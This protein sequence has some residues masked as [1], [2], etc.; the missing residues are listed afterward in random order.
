MIPGSVRTV[1]PESPCHSGRAAHRVAFAMP[2]IRNLLPGQPTPLGPTV[3]AEGINFA[4][5]SAGAT[6]VELLLY[7]NVTDQRPS[8][9]IPLT[10]EA[11]RTGDVWHIFVEGCR[12]TRR[13][14]TIASTVPTGRT[15]DGSRYNAA[16]VL[17]DP[18]TPAVTGDFYWRTADALGYDNTKPDDPD[19]HLRIGAVSNVDGASRCVAYRSDF[20]W[21]GDR[22]PDI[23]IEE[24]IIY[25]VNVRGFTRHHSSES[26]LGGTYR[27]FIEKIP[28]LKDLGV[29]AV[30][31]LPVFEF[32]QFDIPFR[33]PLTG[34]KLTN[35]WG[36][37]TVAFFAPESHYS[38]FGKVGE[39]VDEFKMLVRELH[40]EGIEVILDVVFNH[41][42]E[43]NHY[44]P[45]M[46]FKGLDNNIWYM[47]APKPEFY[48]D[49]TGCGNTMNC[50]HPVVRRFIL[51]CLKYWVTEM[52]VD[53]FRFDLAA[54]FAI[55]V[56]QQEKGKTP[57]IAEIESDPVLARTK[58]IAEPWSITQYRLG[59]FSDRRWAEWN[60]KF[61]D[62]LRRWIKGDGG[63]VND[64]AAR[65]TGSFDLFK[66]NNDT[67]TPYHSINFI[68]CH[69]GFT[70]NDLVSYNDKHNEV[71]GEGNR[72]GSN[73]N[74]SWNCGV[75]GPT[76][77]PEIE[78]LRY[79]QIKN[80]LT[81]LFLSQGTPM[82]LYGDEMRRTALGNNNTVFQDNEL[83]WI[84]W[85][86][87]KKHAEIARFTREIIHF[88]QRHSFVRRRR[89]LTGDQDDTPMIRT[90]TWH[91]VTPG[92]P[93]FGDGSRFIAWVL[94]A[95]QTGERADVPIYI[96]AN[97]YW[98]P[99][100]IELPDIPD[101]RWYRVI[102]TA[103]PTGQDIVP[104]E[105]A[106][107]LTS[108]KVTIEPRST[109]VCVTR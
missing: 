59:S 15:L 43:G 69:D 30:E 31:L 66:E 57:I 28:Y 3:T 14:T 86:D 27:G 83:N 97:A 46:S 53:G 95:F 60:G 13:S 87:A 4:L 102:N 41:T 9:V 45:T 67:R 47:L 62:T 35:A 79:R 94:E 6:R 105:E 64:L 72:D 101:R 16:K 23:P 38:Y 48:M 42:R 85:E 20:D 65:V 89:Y 76:D 99:L 70:L 19:R 107:F 12:R 7:D 22:F 93:D 2:A 54:V 5:H 98:E 81:L 71:N 25:E 17:L 96:A 104:E 39:Q 109:I 100:E 33:N 51:D 26:E 55:D 90:I 75:E 106:V 108:L 1:R 34:E 73:D 50:N 91:G 88:R 18:Y 56:D 11:N 78:R 24:S 77:D 58:L 32:D 36:Y 52:H 74:N 92:H 80:A 37:N 8:Q 82:L 49:F 68:T 63:L 21:Q 103:L 44:G 40:K 10:T 84:N 61:R 29:T